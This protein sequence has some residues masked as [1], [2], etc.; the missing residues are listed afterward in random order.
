[1]THKEIIIIGAGPAGMAAAVQLESMGFRDLLVL[2]KEGQPGG[3]LRQ[4]IHPGFGLIRFGRNLTGPEYSLEY[5]NRMQEASVPVCYDTTVLKV[6]EDETDGICITAAGPEG[7]TEYHC[8]AAILASG[9]RERS[10]G[11][12]MIA[13]TRPAGILTAGTAQGMMNLLN[14]KVGE[15]IVIIGSGDIGLIMARRF[16]L[17]GSRVLCVVEKE[18]V[19][20]GLSRNRKECLDD[21]GIPLLTGAQVIRINGKK[22]VRSVTIREE[23]GTERTMDCDTVI[24]S[25]GLIPEDGFVEGE[26]P[27]LFYCGNALYVHDLVDEVSE[28]GEEAAM[29]AAGFLLAK[30]TGRE[31]FSKY[32]S[33]EVPRVRQERRRYVEGRKDEKRLHR[34]DHHFITCIICPNS[35]RIDL[36]DYTGGQCPRGEVYARNEKEHPFRILTTTVLSENGESI[37]VRTD[38]PVP[39]EELPK[40]MEILRG[41]RAPETVRPGDI[42]LSDFIRQ[43]TNLVATKGSRV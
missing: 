5:E 39:L 3:V 20:G 32:A 21:F 15:R 18:D 8:D 4:C 43:G 25:A 1:M 13:G 28:S 40:G 2:E 7:T 24:L 12:L 27:G 34:D 16:T 31:A 29:D 19:C 41:F 33:E 38:V 42:L 6:R 23:G 30:G 9:C 11:S 35:C 26:V 22:R 10:R 17:E 36:R 37:S 14:T